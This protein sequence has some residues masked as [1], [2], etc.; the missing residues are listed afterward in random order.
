[1]TVSSASLRAAWRSTTVSTQLLRAPL[2][3]LLGPAFAVSIGYIDPGNWATDLGA[4]TFG[5]QLLWVIG[6]SNVIAIILQ[7]AV[8]DLTIATSEEFGVLIARRWK[9]YTFAAWLVFQGAAIATD[10]SEFSGIVLGTQLLFHWS[11]LESV[12]VGLVIVAMVMLATGKR[13][14]AFEYAMIFALGAM[15]VA[16]LFQVPFLHPAWHAVALGALVPH[17]PNGQAV[18]MAVGI[19]GATVMPHNLFLHSALVRSSVQNSRPTSNASHRRFFGRETLVALNIA[20]VVNAAILIVGAAVKSD[21]S[22]Q[23]AIAA[24]LPFGS[25]LG[26]VFG[27]ALLLS[28][29]AASLTAT[30]SG[31]YIF[32]SLAPFHVP[33]ILRRAVTILPAAAVIAAGVSI[34]DILVWSQVALALMLPFALVPLVLL[35]REHRRPALLTAAASALCVA[36]DAVMIVQTLHSS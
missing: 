11:L 2:L 27:G 26:V 7:L 25:F 35:L 3:R 6:L 5:Y 4:G 29:I 18:V 17:L 24:L 10:L 19:I 15:C 14:K 30:V 33:A 13:A 20:A 8:S 9:R 34:T 22:F 21:G 16:C 23:Q 32:R 28:G 36:F 12:A 1:M 31:D